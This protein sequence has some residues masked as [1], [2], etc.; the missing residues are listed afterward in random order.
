M[1]EVLCSRDDTTKQRR[2]GSLV[3]LPFV[4][5]SEKVALIERIEHFPLYKHRMNCIPGG[6]I[7]QSGCKRSAPYP[8]VFL[9]PYHYGCSVVNIHMS[10]PNFKSFQN[11][12]EQGVSN[13]LY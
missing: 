8:H 13:S 1:Q 11:K 2:N 3:K 4:F 6:S 7:F 9:K 10:G 5:A 12:I